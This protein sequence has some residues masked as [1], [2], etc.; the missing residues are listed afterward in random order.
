[1][2]ELDTEVDGDPDSLTE[3][4]RW[5]RERCVGLEDIA[6]AF[7]S[8]RGDSESGWTGEAGDRARQLMT[9]GD[10]LASSQTLLIASLLT[11][12]ETHQDDLNTVHKWMQDARDIA[13]E[14]GLTV[15]GFKIQDPGPAPRDPGT[16]PENASPAEAAQHG[17]LAH[18]N[19]EYTKK[20]QAYSEASEI[21]QKARDKETSSQAQVVQFLSGTFDPAKFAVTLGDISAGAGAAIAARTSAWRTAAANVKSPALASHMASESIMSPAGKLKAATI[22]AERTMEKQ[23]AVNMATATKASQFVDKY[24]PPRIT[25]ALDAKIVPEGTKPPSNMFLRGATKVGGKLPIAGAVFT[26]AG[27]GV[28]VMQG[29]G[30]TQSV[31]S[32]TSGFVGGAVIGAC[33]GGPV[34]AV[35]G[36]VAGVGI[37]FRSTPFGQLRVTENEDR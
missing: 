12:L 32:N 5:M 11:Q 10:K 28:D 8:A 2:A 37:G 31:V 23:F 25:K 9:E 3:S 17:A 24:V 20:V 16:L 4:A 33:I 27:V 14:G 13:R 21:V 7:V 15:R 1:M 34:G 22:A 30:A 18:A 26:A 6:S 36:G 35:V 19:A 29:K